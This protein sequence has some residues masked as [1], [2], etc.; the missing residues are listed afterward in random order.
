V[1]LLLLL[2]T[3]E[4]FVVVKSLIGSNSL[5][6]VLD[7]WHHS[8]Q[9]A[10]VDV[11]TVVEL[12]KDLISVFLNLVLDV[13]L[14][15]LLVLLF[16]AE[17]VVDAE[18]LGVLLLGFLEF[19]IVQ[20]SIAVSDT[21]EQPSLALVGAGGRGVFGK[22]TTDE[23]SV[24]SNTSTGSNH[25]KV[26]LGI[27]FRHEHDLSS[28]TSH[29]DFV[30]RLGVAKE[31]GAD[32]LLGRIIGLEFR[33]PV[34]GTADAEGTSLSR[35]VVTISGRSDRVKA[36]RVGLSVLFTDTRRDYTPRLALPVR[37]VTIMVDDDMASLTS[38]LGSDDSLG[39]DNLSSER[40]LVFVN[41]DRDSRLVIVR[42][43]LKKILLSSNS[44]AATEK[45]K[46]RRVR[47]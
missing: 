17:G 35:H 38:G 40:C 4:P 18:V 41:I 1:P 42:L 23:S 9:T 32:T 28:G 8:L 43:G 10:E 2:Q 29:A 3:L 13:H 24:R 46:V 20:E 31:V 33:A 12:G 7:S 45:K 44:S 26:S 16:T 19:V 25:D 27:F 37:E 30:T 36:D 15:S 34:G 11:S 47:R 5:E 14:S 6:H 21:K 22:E 39:R